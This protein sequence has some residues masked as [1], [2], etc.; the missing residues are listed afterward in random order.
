MI[1]YHKSEPVSAC[2]RRER[3]TRWFR[4]EKAIRFECNVAVPAVEARHSLAFW[5]VSTELFAA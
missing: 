5:G 2:H 3:D 1:L 4:Q